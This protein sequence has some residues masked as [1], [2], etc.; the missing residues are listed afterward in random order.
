MEIQLHSTTKV[1]EFMV[2]G[3][4]VPARVWEGTTANGIPVHL[5]ITRLAVNSEQDQTKFEAELQSHRAPVHV[6]GA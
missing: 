3:R 4:P 1:I 2:D 5:Y 6:K